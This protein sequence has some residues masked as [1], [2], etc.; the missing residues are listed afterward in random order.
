MRRQREGRHYEK[1]EGRKTQRRQREGRHYEKGEGRKTEG[2][3]T[4]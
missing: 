3:K 1:A 4:L 2:R